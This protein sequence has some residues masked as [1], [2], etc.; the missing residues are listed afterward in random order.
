[1]AE[2]GAAGGVPSNEGP[3]TVQVPT[4]DRSVRWCA[5]G[6]VQLSR[7]RV[8]HVSSMSGARR[9]SR[10]LRRSSAAHTVIDRRVGREVEGHRSCV[11]DVV[12]VL[13]R[14]ARKVGTFDNR[15]GRVND[16]GAERP[17]CRSRWR[18]DDVDEG[19]GVV[20]DGADTGRG[21]PAASDGCP[22]IVA[23]FSVGTATSPGQVKV[24]VSP[25]SS[26]RLALP[27]PPGETEGEVQRASVTH[28]GSDAPVRV[29]SH[30]AVRGVAPVLVA[31]NVYV[32]RHSPIPLRPPCH[33]EREPPVSQLSSR[34]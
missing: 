33:D 17:S 12:G 21:A 14:P 3:A 8:L 15:G 29:S 34:C 32:T 10:P 23:E 1:M 24:H 5:L 30:R 16:D 4:R 28:P 7:A 6:P 25:G 19:L 18:G 27:S 20:R 31:A 22:V 13:G 9:C 26:S 2:T 11:V